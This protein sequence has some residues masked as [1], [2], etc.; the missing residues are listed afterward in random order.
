MKIRTLLMHSEKKT[1]DKSI[2]KYKELC[3]GCGLCHSIEN[4]PFNVDEKGFIYPILKGNNASFCKKYCPS[5]ENHSSMIMRVLE[6]NIWG[7]S[8]STYIGWSNNAGIRIKASSGG[9]LTSLCVFL[10]ENGYIDGVIQV[11]ASEDSQ[12][13]TDTV[14]SRSKKDIL[15]CMG[16]RYTTSSPLYKIKD[17]ISEGERYAFVGK[18]CDVSTLRLYLMNDNSLNNQIRYLFSF[19]CAGM[20]SRTANKTLLKE[21]GGT[22]E[23]CTLLT[24]RGNGWPGFATAK[25]LNA[26]DG[27]LTYN[28]AWGNVLGRDLRPAC[29]FCLDGIG[30]MSDVVCGDA[31]YEDDYGN[32]DFSEHEGRNIIFTRTKNGESIIHEASEKGY[33]YL[34]ELKGYNRYLR[35][36]QKYQFERKTT[37]LGT[38]LALKQCG[39]VVPSYRTRKLVKFAFMSSPRLVLSRYKGTI[40]RILDNKI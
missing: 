6:K 23:T 39:R 2:D 17:L 8:E 9:V 31:W 35:K 33:L 36:I 7:Q 37:M 30:L 5:S 40:K 16:S 26:P 20:P 21:L 13:D 18:P 25:F 38:V 10:L 32:P 22:E 28:D 14:I 4:V 1:M 27:R 11:R 19:F 34:T 15:N 24:Y 29:R 12:I 3:T